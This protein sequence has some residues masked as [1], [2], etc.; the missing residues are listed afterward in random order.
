MKKL[1]ITISLFVSLPLLAAITTGYNIPPLSAYNGDIVSNVTFV[2]CTNLGNTYS[3][4]NVAPV[5]LFQAGLNP[6]NL[7]T[8][9]TNSTGK[10]SIAYMQAFMTTGGLMTI[11]NATAGVKIYSICLSAGWT[12]TITV[13]TGPGD[14]LVLNVENGTGGESTNIWQ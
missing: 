13:N 4:N 11:S 5:P 14:R 12:N 6:T 1:L 7:P 8:L 9:I 10:Q 3:S 2:A